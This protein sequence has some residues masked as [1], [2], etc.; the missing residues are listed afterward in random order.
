[1]ELVLPGGRI[2]DREMRVTGVPDFVVGE[3]VIVFVSQDRSEFVPIVGVSQGTFRVVTD[4]GSGD[5]VVAP[6]DVERLTRMNGPVREQNRRAG[7]A[8]RSRG[9]VS[10][11]AAF[12]ERID[13]LVR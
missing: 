6:A 9:A 2:G 8:S 4:P 12:E 11:L 1:M 13:A 10:S 5:Q 3:R 7:A